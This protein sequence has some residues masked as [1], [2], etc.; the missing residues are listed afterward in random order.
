VIPGTERQG[1]IGINQ[2]VGGIKSEVQRFNKGGTPLRRAAA[3]A[4]FW[5]E[6]CKEDTKGEGPRTSKTLQ[7]ENSYRGCVETLNSR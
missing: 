4:R 5:Y 7:I 3:L 6:D 2:S 1:K